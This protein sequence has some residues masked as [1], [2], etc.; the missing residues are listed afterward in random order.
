MAANGTNYGAP[1][2][3]SPGELAEVQGIADGGEATE[4]NLHSVVDLSTVRGSTF[5]VFSI[6]QTLQQTPVGTVTIQSEQYREAIICQDA[7]IHH[8]TVLWKNISQ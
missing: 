8:A 7:Q 1:F 4:Q 6:G 3:I 2:Y 5:R